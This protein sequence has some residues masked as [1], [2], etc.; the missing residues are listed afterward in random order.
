M[1]TTAA[2][3]APLAVPY[4]RTSRLAVKPERVRQT[5]VN[6]V[7]ANFQGSTRPSSAP[8]HHESGG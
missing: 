6:A 8:S 1:Y 3:V 4:L 2:R 7:V 5:H